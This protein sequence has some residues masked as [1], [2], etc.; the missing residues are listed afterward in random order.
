M[1]VCRGWE[2]VRGCWASQCLGDESVSKLGLGAPKGSKPGIVA[3]S[4]MPW[5]YLLDLK[6]LD[7]YLGLQK[8]AF[9]FG[10]AKM[11]LRSGLA[12]GLDIGHW[13]WVLKK[14]KKTNNNNNK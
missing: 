11:G 5:A 4:T 7:Q 14:E 3:G 13:A 12:I 10:L 6:V 9:A 8:W 1:G 2:R